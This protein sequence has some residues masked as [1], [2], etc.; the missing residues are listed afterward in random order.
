M[1]FDFLK[2][3][4]SVKTEMIISG[5]KVINII[6]EGSYGCVYL[7]TDSELNKWAIKR[8]IKSSLDSE[9]LS[10]FNNEIDIAS[11]VYHP[12]LVNLHQ[13]KRD[14][15]SIDLIYE[16]CDLGSLDLY[17]SKLKFPMSEKLALNL[18]KDIAQGYYE[19]YTMHILHR[20]IKLENILLQSSKDGGMCA[21]I[22]DFGFSKK[23]SLC[24][25]KMATSY[26]GSTYY[27][28]PEMLNNKAY[29]FENDIF[30]I[31]IVCYY[32]LFHMF[33]FPAV[34]ESDLT[35]QY[36]IGK[37]V[38]HG[39]RRPLCKETA[40]L[41]YRCLMYDPHKRITVEDFIHH[42]ALNSS[43]EELQA[44]GVINTQVEFNIKE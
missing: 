4:S 26:M 15:G 23:C 10:V 17:T 19:L 1:D 30:G 16:Y 20:D 36:S 12:H 43:Y 11:K 28:S 5:Y 14:S 38:I 35:E 8:M 32:M 33:P 37:L 22:G 44:L 24:S 27:M 34:T 29:N 25:S 13:I 2:E 7:A 31:G 41:I 6:G 42:K 21:K 40:I 39:E 18:I 3:V 9:A